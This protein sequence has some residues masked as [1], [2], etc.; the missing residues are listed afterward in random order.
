MSIVSHLEPSKRLAEPV[1]SPRAE[2]AGQSV[3]FQ[4]GATIGYEP[5]KRPAEPVPYR[6]VELAGRTVSYGTRSVFWLAAGVLVFTPW[7]WAGMKPAALSASVWLAAFLLASLLVGS[8]R[9]SGRAVWRDPLFVTGLSFL[10]YLTIQWWNSGRLL[11]F[12][13]GWQR[14][15]H[16]APFRPGWPSGFDRAETGQMLAWF[17]PPWCVALALR[18]T[19]LSAR[20]IAAILRVIVWSAGLLALVGIGQYAAGAKA[21]Y[22]VTPLVCPFFASFPYANHAAAF[23]LM[24]AALA[25]GLLFHEAFRL[26]RPVS[27]LL[28][29]SFAAS[30]A[31]CLAGANLSL[32]RAGVLLAW[33]FAFFAAGFALWNGWRFLPK[34]R[35]VKQAAAA[36]GL[37]A[38]TALAVAEMGDTAILREFGLA[39]R[40][41]AASQATAAGSLNLSMGGRSRLRELGWRVWREAPWFGV[42]GWG[43]KHRSA[44]H[45]PALEWKLLSIKGWAN[46]HCDSLQFL[47]EFGLVGTLLGL[48]VLACLL[49]PLARA[50]GWSCNFL[51]MGLAG[52]GMVAGLSLIDIPFRCPAILVTWT[53]ILAA[54]P[55]A[56]GRPFSRNA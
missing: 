30:L 15:E 40:D 55:R 13:A 5:S 32:S 42:G 53:G 45:L 16:T 25:T 37:L 12:D 36:G 39:G 2:P 17:F 48:S 50:S 4:T 9:A 24:M 23:F 11:Y 7:A 8:I 26:D 28:S 54:L 51:V 35:R 46:V 56:A 6:K 49:V 34:A 41:A 33:V 1:S 19:L 29:A 21:L 10:A 14:W 20:R 18:S 44:F 52:L 22:G 38:A 43:F 27:L 31:L 47:A 3:S